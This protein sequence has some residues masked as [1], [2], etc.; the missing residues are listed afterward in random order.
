VP[1]SL[2]DWT[3]AR[4][5]MTSRSAGHRTRQHPANGNNRV[6]IESGVQVDSSVA[7]L[8]TALVM[9]VY[10]VFFTSG[11]VDGGRCRSAFDGPVTARTA[12]R[13]PSEDRSPNP[14]LPSGRAGPAS[15]RAGFARPGRV[16]LVQV[17]RPAGRTT[18]TRRARSGCV[19]C[20]AGRRS[21][22]GIPERP[23]PGLEALAAGGA[24]RVPGSRSGRDRPNRRRAGGA[25]RARRLATPPASGCRRAVR[26]VRPP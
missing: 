21:A 10:L 2:A 13:R 25:A 15:R 26:C 3:P 8:L 18:W 5:W 12:H 23:G 19:W 1:Y 24:V 20:A 16:R 22:P 9:A 7:L 6:T 4:H 11:L 17:E 14:L